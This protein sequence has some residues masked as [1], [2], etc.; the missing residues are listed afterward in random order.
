[1]I[2]QFYYSQR[3]VDYCDG[4]IPRGMT[5]LMKDI[6]LAKK[7]AKGVYL[8]NKIQDILFDDVFEKY[9]LH[10]QVSY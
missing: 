9:F 5:T 2:S 6:S 3:F 7:G 8:Y 4:V 1:M 10:P